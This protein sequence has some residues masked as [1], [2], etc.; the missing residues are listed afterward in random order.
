MAGLAI[1]SHARLAGV[2]TLGQAREM[3]DTVFHGQCAR[4]TLAP[5]RGPCLLHE[6]VAAALNA[7][8]VASCFML[9]GSGGVLDGDLRSSLMDP[10]SL[11]L[12]GWHDLKSKVLMYPCSDFGRLEGCTALVSIAWLPNH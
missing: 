1:V 7:S 4:G 11:W 3:V 2:A 12:C 6:A 5:P 10:P 8:V 9:L